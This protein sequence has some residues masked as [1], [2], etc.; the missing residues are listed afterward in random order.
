MIENTLTVN[1][2][3]GELITR[4]KYYFV[5]GKLIAS[6]VKDTIE[7]IQILIEEEKK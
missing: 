6:I 7:Y 1:A 5:D 3:I 2:I 4:E